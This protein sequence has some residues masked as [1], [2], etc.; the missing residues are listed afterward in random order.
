MNNKK[1]KY[2]D[3]PRSAEHKVNGRMRKQILP[4]LLIQVTMYRDVTD[5]EISQTGMKHMRKKTKTEVKLQ[6]DFH[7][8]LAK[9][10]WNLLK[11]TMHFSEIQQKD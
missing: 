1:E 8:F 4:H 7:H 9:M 10:M 6:Q 11:L 2:R 5:G 3:L